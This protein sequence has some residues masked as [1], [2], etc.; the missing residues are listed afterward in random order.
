MAISLSDFLGLTK[1]V[2]DKEGCFEGCGVF[3]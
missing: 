1:D 2:L 3:A